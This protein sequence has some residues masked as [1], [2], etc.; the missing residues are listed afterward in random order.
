MPWYRVTKTIR[1]REYDYWQ[2]T[3][4]VGRSVKTENIYIG[5]TSRNIQGQHALTIKNNYIF[6]QADRERQTRRLA[7]LQATKK[8][9]PFGL[10]KGRY[11]CKRCETQTDRVDWEGQCYACEPSEAN[12]P[13]LW[14]YRLRRVPYSGS[15]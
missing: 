10:D 8:S 7:A 12:K 2:Q 14:R 4:R 3:H 6:I 15:G 11:F 5:P 1:G 9:L 13:S